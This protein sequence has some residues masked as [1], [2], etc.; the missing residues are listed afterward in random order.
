[1]DNSK[2][3]L[4]SQ[5]RTGE[6][7]VDDSKNSKK[8]RWKVRKEQSLAVSEAYF[9]VEELMKYGEKMHHCGS[10]LHFKQC[11]KGHEKKLFRADFCKGRGCPMCQWR[12]S[13]AIFSKLL[14]LVHAHRAR[15]TSDIPLFLTLTVPNVPSAELKMTS[16]MMQKSFHKLTKRAKFKGSIRSFFRSFEV[17]YNSE[18]DTYHPHFHVLLMVPKDYFTLKRGLYIDRNEWLSMWQESTGISEITQVDIRRVKKKSKN[19]PIEAIISEVAK[20]A[21]KPSSYIQESTN[22]TYNADV[23]VVETLHY[24]LKSRRLI[25]FG[26]LFNELGRLLKK[27]EPKEAAPCV[28]SICQSDL[29]DNIFFSWYPELRQYMA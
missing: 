9:S 21:V 25:A 17:T 12:K 13:L 29:F 27:S 5:F 18:N 22:G 1:M 26:G 11:P 6:I 23:K 3:T 15:Y 8:N 10:H 24:A 19:R 2:K 20:Y 16:D 4:K 28:C 7:L 14:Q